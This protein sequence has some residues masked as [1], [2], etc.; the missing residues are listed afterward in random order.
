MHTRAAADEFKATAESLR[1]TSRHDSG[2]VVVE[3]AGEVDA[4]TG[5]PL[6]ERLVGLDLAGYHHLVIDMTAVGFMDSSGLG[7]LVGAAKR[8]RVNGGEVT[9]VGAAERILSVLRITGLTRVFP[10]FST[11]AESLSPQPHRYAA[12][13]E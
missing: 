4:Y 2:R 10:V 3:I 13:H 1:I 8:A 7:I 11:V 5:A 6:R 12:H 9:I